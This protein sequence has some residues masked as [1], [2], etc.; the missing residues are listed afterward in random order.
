MGAGSQSIGNSH[1]AA[2]EALEGRVLMSADMVLAWNRNMVHIFQADTALPGPTVAARDMAIMEV[3]MSDAVAATGGSYKPY[4]VQERAPSDTSPNAA[5][6]GAAFESLWRLFPTMHDM[7]AAD[8]NM[9]LGQLGT[10]R[11]VTKGLSWGEHVA[12]VIVDARANDGS[13]APVQYLPGTLPGQWQPDPLNPGQVAWGPGEGQVTPF[14]LQS[15]SQFRPPAPPALDSQAYADAFNQ[16]KTLGAKDSTVRTADQTQIGIFWAYDRPGMGSP[17][18]MY[19]EAAMTIAQQKHN[20]MHQNARM[21]ALLGI[22]EADAGFA[23]WDAKYVYDFWRPITAIRNADPTTNPG[24]I[25]DSTW[26]PLGAPG[27][28]VVPNFTPPFPAYISG[29]S[30]FGA[31]A[32]ETLK[33][34]YGTDKMHFTL[35]SDEL[36]GVTRSYTSFSQAADE[37][38][39]S[40]I[41]LGIHWNFDNEMGKA[42]GRS[43]A[44]Y[45]FKHELRPQA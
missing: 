18:M 10:S 19:D 28:G 22:A 45:V 6:A 43:V 37:N 36:P 31:A 26:Q 39:M 9:S 24:T 42:T 5:A 1:A 13:N 11:A 12:D 2:V 3:A 27:D 29:H 34:F 41:Y 33:N 8:L 17:L 38:G 25:P 32:F 30:T 35:M 16:V 40:R 44:D 21:F 15:D 14:A 23:A 7:L 20:T 4:L